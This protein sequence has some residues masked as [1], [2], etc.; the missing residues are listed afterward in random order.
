M[1][2]LD[3]Y[4]VPIRVCSLRPSVTENS[5]TA[6]NSLSEDS[7]S[8]LYS[9]TASASLG[10]G[11]VSLLPVSTVET[12]FLGSSSSSISTKSAALTFAALSENSLT[13]GRSIPE[14]SSTPSDHGGMLEKLPSIV[15]RS[16]EL[17]HVELYARTIIT[18]TVTKYGTNI[19]L[20]TNVPINDGTCRE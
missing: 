15:T 10:S 12:S 13:N 17:I 19:F 7:P 9:G 5:S 18:V 1:I 11:A 3:N 8:T 16:L 6:S 4:G 2:K 20:P 14:T